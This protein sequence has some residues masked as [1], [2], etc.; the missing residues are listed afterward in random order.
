M[1][2]RQPSQGRGK[3]WDPVGRPWVWGC[4]W[5]HPPPCEPWLS[6]PLALCQD[7]LKSPWFILPAECPCEHRVQ[8]S[9][10]DAAPKGPWERK[11]GP[12]PGVRHAVSEPRV[13]GQWRVWWSLPRGGGRLW[14]QGD[15]SCGGHACGNLPPCGGQLG[16]SGLPSAAQCRPGGLKGPGFFLS[17]GGWMAEV[18]VSG[19]VPSLASLLGVPVS[20]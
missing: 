5:E 16:L 17:P 13:G 4:P 19:L 12:L 2:V 7:P 15:S 20:L 3:C 9:G 14:S 10:G 8:E 18:G 1:Q 6:L 11:L